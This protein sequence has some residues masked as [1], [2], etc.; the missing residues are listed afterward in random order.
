MYICGGLVQLY[1]LCLCVHQLLDAVSFIEKSH[2]FLHN[3]NIELKIM[4]I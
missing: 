4:I 3:L 1:I 2:R